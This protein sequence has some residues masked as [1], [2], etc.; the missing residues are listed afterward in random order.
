[1]LLFRYSTAEV[2]TLNDIKSRGESYR[3]TH[4]TK[5]LVI[6]NSSE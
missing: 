6:Q 2:E 5:E 1:M 3:V 4:S